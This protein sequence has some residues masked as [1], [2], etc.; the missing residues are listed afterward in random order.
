[1]KLRR[2]QCSRFFPANHF[3]K[4]QKTHF[5]EKIWS[6][7]G[8]KDNHDDSAYQGFLT[9]NPGKE[10]H[11][12]LVYHGLTE[13]FNFSGEKFTTIRPVKNYSA[14]D[15]I[16][17]VSWIGPGGRFTPG[18]V[19][20]KITGPIEVKRVWDVEI[21]GRGG[22]ILLDSNE[23]SA[24]TLLRVATNDGLS[25]EDFDSWFRTKASFSGQIVSWGNHVAY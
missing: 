8:I 25:M 9:L 17:F 15:I 23:I 3:K 4:G 20:L 18:N 21:E 6:S 12:R 16:Q 2:V 24:D 19:L 13:P 5:I 7:I 1:M 22:S 10:G 11:V 14:G